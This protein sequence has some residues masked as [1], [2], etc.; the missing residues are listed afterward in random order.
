[1]K[2]ANF[3]SNKRSLLA[4][5]AGLL[6][7]AACLGGMAACSSTPMEMRPPAGFEG[8]SLTLPAAN[9]SRATGLLVDE[10]FDLGAYRVTGIEGKNSSTGG[11]FQIGGLKVENRRSAFSY[12]LVGGNSGRTDVAAQCASKSNE[13]TLPV[14]SAVTL[15]RYKV[16]FSCDCRTQ[17][18]HSSTLSIASDSGWQG[19]AGSNP[20]RLSITLDEVEYPLGRFDANG[21]T[22]PDDEPFAGYRVDGPSGP[23]AALGLSYPGTVWLHER[24]PA[25]KREVMSCALAGLMLH[26][27][28]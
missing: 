2:Q 10:S 15:Q 9:R 12:H 28:P 13:T 17:D 19:A 25:A 8:Q 24:L 14:F 3:N 5:G 7:A 26:R 16:N 1:M 27:G 4:T 11:S 6:L 21:R 23:V 20:V 22:V 18:G